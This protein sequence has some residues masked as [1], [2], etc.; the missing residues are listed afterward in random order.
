MNKFTKKT[1]AMLLS[2]ALILSMFAA[3][4]SDEPADSSSP[5]NSTASGEPALPEVAS[6]F[7]PTG[8]PIVNETV[9]YNVVAYQAPNS[10]K[11]ME[12]KYIFEK[13][14]AE[15]NVVLEFEEIPSTAWS[16]KLN[17][18]V[19]TGDV[20]DAIIGGQF[21]N[22]ESAIDAELIV[23]WDEYMDY[24]PQL[25]KIYD[26]YPIADVASSYEGDGKH[27][28]FPS[29]GDKTYSE[30]RAPLFIN[31]TWLDTLGLPVPTTTDEFYET[32][33]AFKNGDPNGNG[34]ADEIPLANVDEFFGPTFMDLF[35]AWDMMGIKNPMQTTVRDG[36]LDF[37]PVTDNYRQALEYFSKLYNEG[38]MEAEALTMKAAVKNSKAVAEPA[39]YGAAVE[40]N[41]ETYGANSDQYIALEPLIGPDGAQKYTFN[42]TV[43]VTPGMVIFEGCENPEVLM[44]YMD[45]ANTGI[46]TL[47]AHYGEEG[48]L[49]EV[50]E[51]AKTYRVKDT[52]Y[53]EIGESA[54]SHRVTEGIQN[55]FSTPLASGYTLVMDDISSNKTKQNWTDMY[56]PYMFD[57]Y[58][59]FS[60]QIPQVDEQTNQINLL[61]NELDTYLSAFIADAIINGID[62]EKWA[63]HLSHCEALQYETVVAHHQ[64][65]YDATK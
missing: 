25:Q 50:D 28:Y 52:E 2:S 23:A 20:P 19:S 13:L 46:N 4:S 55:N 12:E 17:I 29:I 56:E 43:Q 27:Y 40:W 21:A 53:A 33:V 39:V 58:F 3:C 60:T 57:E 7:N 64:A 49:F 8:L 18:M 65:R 6:N 41:I 26:T 54:E 24:L 10:K 32:L 45:H 30:T 31:K 38:L 35:G 36:Q 63:D 47:I 14:E 61:T 1:L 22:I 9:T 42:D 48:L 59:P 62:D 34:V 11:P 51:D 15:T 44:R 16:E 37:N 5:T